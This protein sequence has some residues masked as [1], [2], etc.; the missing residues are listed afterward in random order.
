LT[1]LETILLI[2]RRT[3]YLKGYQHMKL[4]RVITTAMTIGLIAV[5]GGAVATATPA[6]AAPVSQQAGEP[7]IDAL[8]DLQKSMEDAGI[9][10]SVT[11]EN[12]ELLKSYD[13]GRV[14]VDTTEPAPVEPGTIAPRLR[15]GVGW[16]IYVYF[17]RQDQ[18]DLAV[19][20]GAFL[21]GVIAAANPAAG[22]IAGPAVAIAANRV[23][24][25]GI[26]GNELELAFN[27]GG[28]L[29]SAKCV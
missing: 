7:T 8:R 25:N 11:I 3:E 9:Q 10:P 29:Q 28:Q 6:Q 27:F 18:T 26:C 19:G 16:N 4:T 13:Q 1:I 17:N 5:G 15:V 12:G 22:I 24:T 2:Q 21:V 20:S 23:A 14:R